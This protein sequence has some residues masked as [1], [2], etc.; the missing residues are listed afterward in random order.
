MQR[1]ARCC[2]EL[3]D[4]FCFFS[5][6]CQSF[7]PALDRHL[8]WTRPYLKGQ[9]RSNRCN[10]ESCRNS[11]SSCD[12]AAVL[13]QQ[14]NRRKA[15]TKFQSNFCTGLRTKLILA[16]TRRCRRNDGLPQTRPVDRRP[17]APRK[18]EPLNTP[19]TFSTQVV[20][21]V[22]IF[23]ISAQRVHISGLG[24]GVVGVKDRRRGLS[25]STTATIGLSMMSCSCVSA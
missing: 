24:P 8:N 3:A 10:C 17:T 11:K 7:G 5:F 21:H 14:T 2:D 18:R 15:L 13:S 9:D 16:S 22:G 4:L 1:R 20:R 19:T 25:M 6:G 12:D 23:H